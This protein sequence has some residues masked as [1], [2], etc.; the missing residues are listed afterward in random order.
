MDKYVPVWHALSIN[1][2]ST[3]KTVKPLKKYTFN[4]NGY[5]C[6]TLFPKFRESKVNSVN[7]AVIA[8]KGNPKGNSEHLYLSR[9]HT[10][11]I[12]FKHIVYTDKIVVYNLSF[13]KDKNKNEELV[14]NIIR[15]Y[16]DKHQKIPAYLKNRKKRF[17]LPKKSVLNLPNDANLCYAVNNLENIFKNN[18]YLTQHGKYKVL[19]KT[20]NKKTLIKV[21][22]KVQKK[23]TVKNTWGPEPSKKDKIINLDF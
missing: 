1:N 21:K 18:I 14:D 13:R 17:I 10:I 8:V 3:L 19:F 4:K 15:Y 12:K 5:V 23:V 16:C 9:P 11:L 20:K 2:S 6:H 7:L 22:V